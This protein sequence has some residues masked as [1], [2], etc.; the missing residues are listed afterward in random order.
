MEA[1]TSALWTS[2]QAAEELLAAEVEHHV[3]AL[4]ELLVRFDENMKAWW[5]LNAVPYWCA[6]RPAIVK[7]REDQREMVLHALD[8]DAYAAYYAN[9]PGEHPFEHQFGVPP[10]RGHERIP[11]LAYLR[12]HLQPAS[13]VLDL[14]G[15]DGGFAANLAMAGHTV[16]CMDL[17]PDCCERARQRPGVGIVW[18]GDLRTPPL[19][20]PWQEY[21]A[22]VLFEVIEHLPDPGEELARIAA[23]LK[24]GTAMFVS[25]PC[26][27][28]E[29]GNL[30]AWADVI[31]K[32][33]LWSLT[34]AMFLA[35]LERCGHVVDISLGPDNVMI[36]RVIV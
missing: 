30:P 12:E 7:A 2:H 10:E 23:R 5:L 35:A 6:E 27:A 4:R 28:V 14:S 15:N 29:R 34:P 25:T 8:E 17:N 19:G 11:R 33:H 21:D 22:V 1:V 13:K 16:D 24:A 36:G 3:L 18:E 31:R 20:I 9:N 26:G 32:G